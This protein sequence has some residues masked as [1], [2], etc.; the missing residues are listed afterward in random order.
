VIR[1][2]GHADATGV[3]VRGFGQPADEDRLDGDIVFFTNLELTGKLNAGQ[4]VEFTR[5]LEAGRKRAREVVV[6]DSSGRPA[7]KLSDD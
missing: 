4:R 3:A 5:T 7:V 2:L 1:K 6:L